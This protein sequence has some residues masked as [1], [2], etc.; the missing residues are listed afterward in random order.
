MGFEVAAAELIQVLGLR[1]LRLDVT[2]GALS[3]NP[4]CFFLHESGWKGMEGE[5]AKWIGTNRV[6]FGC[7]LLQECYYS[8]DRF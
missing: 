7:I 3:G 8:T 1:C 2:W 5:R 4:Q 6:R